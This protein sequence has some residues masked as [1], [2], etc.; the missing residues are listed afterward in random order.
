MIPGGPFSCILADPPWRF[1]HYS[2]KGEVKSA[3]RHYAC[4]SLDDIKAIPVADVA[5]RD[6]YLFLWATGPMIAEALELIPAWG[7]K[8][9]AMAFVWVKTNKRAP[10]LF[11]DARAIFK[12][13]GYTTR[14]NAEFVLLGRRGRPERLSKSVS[15]IIVAPRREHSRKPDEVFDRVEAFCAG[16]RLELFARET[17][18]GWASFGNETTKFDAPAIAPALLSGGDYDTRDGAA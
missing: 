1:D 11:W 6:C 12:G 14:Q 13:M 8:Y 2:T 7:F 3:Q 9:S 5:A 17:R 10:V 4:A 18:P 15:Q 16:P